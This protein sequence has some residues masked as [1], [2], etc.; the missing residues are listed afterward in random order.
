MLIFYKQSAKTKMEK[1]KTTKIPK[2]TL[3][4]LTKK[5]SKSLI[6]KIKEKNEKINK[7]S[8]SS[9]YNVMALVVEVF[10]FLRLL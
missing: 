7:F 6:S 3:V 5:K 4:Q 2:N 10:R 8:G 9:L 1:N